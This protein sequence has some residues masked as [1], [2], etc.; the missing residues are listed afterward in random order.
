MLIPV[1][2][3][4]IGTHLFLPAVRPRR[5][6]RISCLPRFSRQPPCV[7][8]RPFPIRQWVYPKVLATFQKPVATTKTIRTWLVILANVWAGISPAVTL[9][10]R[11]GLFLSLRFT[12]NVRILDLYVGVVPLQSL[13]A[14]S[15]TTR[16]RC[17]MR[18]DAGHYVSNALLGL[19]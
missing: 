9:R 17:N 15:S 18:S 12:N 6:I 19:G 11:P 7:P 5:A 3:G 2:T 13:H 16:A 4:R 14:V 8:Q 1:C 10:R